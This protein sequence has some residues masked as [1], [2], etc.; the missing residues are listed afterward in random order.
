MST[1]TLRKRKSQFHLGTKGQGGLLTSKHI[2]VFYVND[3]KLLE[4]MEWCILG[5]KTIFQNAKQAFLFLAVRVIKRSGVVKRAKVKE[6]SLWFFIELSLPKSFFQ[7]IRGSELSVRCLWGRSVERGHMLQACFC[8]HC[9][10][11]LTQRH[12]ALILWTCSPVLSA[13]ISERYRALQVEVFPGTK[14]LCYI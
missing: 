3:T 8:G 1:N 13:I 11:H 4:K 10:Q 14:Y 12:A 6:R 7:F 2:R 9:W 5:V